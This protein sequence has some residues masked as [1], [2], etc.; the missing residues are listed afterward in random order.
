MTGAPDTSARTF[1]A[2]ALRE[3]DR[4]CVDEFAIP[5]IVLM[6]NAASAM[7]AHTLALARVRA[8]TGALILAGPG[9]NGGD[10]YAL[11]RH[12][13]NAAFPVR[14]AVAAPSRDGSDAA[15]NRTICARTGLDILDANELLGPGAL[16]GAAPGAR[17]LLVDALLGTGLDRDVAG[18]VRRLIESVNASALPVV[19]AD[20]PSG[21]D[22]DTGRPLGVCVRADLTCT[23]AGLKRG[24]SAP[25]AESLTG[26]V[27]L[28]P[29]G[30]PRAL[31]DRLA[32]TPARE[33][34]P[35]LGV[36]TEPSAP[37]D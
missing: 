24:F 7:A 2:A 37:H 27:R 30:A 9:N 28:C 34:R 33:D 5:S 11:A 22:A 19:A 14:L 16:A 25:G 31:L 1:S 17:P 15:I 13:S 18:P 35:G 23:F 21:M 3:I 26:A 20:L 29:I 8:L 10:G 32:D 12:L 36:D 6:E 4:L